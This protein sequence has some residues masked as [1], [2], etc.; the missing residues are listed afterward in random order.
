MHSC[1]CFASKSSIVVSSYVFMMYLIVMCACAHVARSTCE[2]V[3]CAHARVV[4]ACM[5]TCAKYTLHVHTSSSCTMRA[6]DVVCVMTFRYIERVMHQR[7][8]V[9]FRNTIDMC[10][11]LCVCALSNVRDMRMRS[12]R[13]SFSIVFDVTRV[14]RV[15]MYD[16]S[17]CMTCAYAHRCALCVYH[18]F[19]NVRVVLFDDLNDCLTCRVLRMSSHDINTT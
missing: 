13:V 1:A 16:Q 18:V 11:R 15:N 4:N 14:R 5:C 8:F 12:T 7:D 17:L 19:C 9:M 3:T 10:T 2:R 6:I